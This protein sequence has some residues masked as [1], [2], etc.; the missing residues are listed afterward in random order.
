MEK[1]ITV[2]VELVYRKAY[3]FDVGEEEYNEWKDPWSRTD[4]LESALVNEAFRKLHRE[5][6]QG[7]GYYDGGTY[8]YDSDYEIKDNEGKVVM[9]WK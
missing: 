6:E 2:T 5:V 4:S 9:S 7:K 8:D 3:E 1:K